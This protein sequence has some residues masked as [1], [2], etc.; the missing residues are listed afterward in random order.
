MNEAMDEKIQGIVKDILTDVEKEHNGNTITEHNQPD[1][2]EIIEII[3]N[4]QSVLFPVHWGEKKDISDFAVKYELGGLIER[5]YTSLSVQIS[6]ALRCHP[7]YQKKSK[8]VRKADAKEMAVRFL[9]KMTTIREYLKT[10]IQAA[11]DGDPAA[12]NKDEIIFSYPGFYAILVNRIAHEL[13][14][15]KIPLIPRIMTE[16]AHGKTGI[17]IH[18]GASIGKYFFIDHGTGVVIGET[19]TIGDHVKLY[20]GVTLGGLSTRAGQGLRD[21]KRHPTIG[22]QVTIYSNASVLGGDT[23]IGDG[24]VI[25]GNCFVTRSIPAHMK[26]SNPGFQLEM[27]PDEN[28]LTDVGEY[29]SYEI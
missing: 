11:F 18:P 26:V 28:A 6:R 24:C 14:L 20:Q 1:R 22:N 21:V 10:D 23:V 2:D 9:D 19:T 15:M 27:R 16:Y 13:Y 17:D 7:A 5:I 8:A 29:W 4:I 3:H 25:G 12:F